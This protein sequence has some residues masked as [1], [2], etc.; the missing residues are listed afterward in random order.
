MSCGNCDCQMGCEGVISDD[1]QFCPT[2]FAGVDSSEHHAKCVRPLEVAE[3]RVATALAL[4]DKWA[5]DSKRMGQLARD[6]AAMQ[7]VYTTG[8]A[9][10][11]RDV[12]TDLKAAMKR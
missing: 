7:P 8:Y 6:G 2:C 9:K 5:L 10:A 11:L 3:D 12:A 4:A 1:E